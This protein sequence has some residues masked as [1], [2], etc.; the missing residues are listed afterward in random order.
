MKENR[1]MGNSRVYS[2][3]SFSGIYEWKFQD[4]LGD[5]DLT[6]GEVVTIMELLSA[7][8]NLKEMSPPWHVE[9][10]TYDAKLLASLDDVIIHYV[11]EDFAAKIFLSEDGK[12]PKAGVTK[13]KV[14]SKK[15]VKKK[16]K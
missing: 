8:K 14:A 2:A 5:I 10:I 15:A 13:K 11:G 7:R 1:T 9:D 16:G 3:I 4:I 6:A 12:K